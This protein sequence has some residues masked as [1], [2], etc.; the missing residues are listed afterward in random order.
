[1]CKGFFPPLTLN[2]SDT[3]WIELAQTPQVKGSDNKTACTSYFKHKSQ[4]ITCASYWSWGSP[5]LFFG[6]D[7]LLE[8][9]IELRKAFDWL[10][11]CY[12]F[13]TKNI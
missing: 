13:I 11:Y 12:S 2:K 9:L 10:I 1:M 6:F 5:E 7:N 4:V 3:N 8:W